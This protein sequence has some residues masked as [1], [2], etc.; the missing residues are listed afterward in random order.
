MCEEFD[1]EELS[2]RWPCGELK[3]GGVHD[4]FGCPIHGSECPY[5]DEDEEEYE[6]EATNV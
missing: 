3:D 2:D 5:D 6:E 1:E 4:E